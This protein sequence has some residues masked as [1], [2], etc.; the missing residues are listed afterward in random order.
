MPKIHFFLVTCPHCGAKYKIKL[1][2][3][4][5]RETLECYACGDSIDAR[6]YADML[7]LIYAYSQVVV[8]L[9][10]H[11]KVDEDVFIPHG[12]VQIVKRIAE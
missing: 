10:G 5:T 3:I 2:R 4:E 12:Q 9:E 1:E 7:D 8:K 6:P 11:G